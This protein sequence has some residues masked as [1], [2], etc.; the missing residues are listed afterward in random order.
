MPP[1]VHHT[2]GCI[3]NLAVPGWEFV[4]KFSIPIF[5]SKVRVWFYIGASCLICRAFCSTTQV[6]LHP[7]WY[8]NLTVEEFLTVSHKEKRKL[9]WNFVSHPRSLLLKDQ[10]R[11]GL[12]VLYHC[13]ASFQ[14]I[15]SSIKTILFSL[16]KYTFIRCSTQWGVM[17]F[18]IFTKFYWEV[19]SINIFKAAQFKSS[20]ILS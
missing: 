20:T 11:L 10:C 14:K 4:W 2:V 13:Y 6:N 3:D 19:V 15:W 16:E 8:Y 12:L 17:I 7:A 5:C 1:V 9:T 18:I